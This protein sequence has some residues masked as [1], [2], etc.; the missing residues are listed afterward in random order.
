MNI[1]SSCSFITAHSITLIIFYSIKL[2][3]KRVDLLSVYSIFSI[4]RNLKRTCFINSLCFIVHNLSW[5]N[6]VAESVQPIGSYHSDYTMKIAYNDLLIARFQNR[7]LQVR[8][9]LNSISMI[10]LSARFPAKFETVSPQRCL[11]DGRRISS[12][13]NC[14][15]YRNFLYKFYFHM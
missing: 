10:G 15:K 7:E 14:R 2:A 12:F 8:A 3:A 11:P 6:F 5:F 13:R 4:M 1:D 9:W